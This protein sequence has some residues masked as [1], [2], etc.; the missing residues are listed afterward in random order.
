VRQAISG[1][2]EELAALERLLDETASG[3]AALILEGEPGIGKT[4]LFDAGRELARARG[5]VVLTAQPAP[6]EIRLAHA[7]LAD[8]LGPVALQALEALPGAQ[9]DA[10][11][12]AL[13]RNDATAPHAPDRRAVAAALLTVVEHLAAT[14]PVLIAIDD[15][16]WL[17][18]SSAAAVT[19]ALRRVTGSAG[20]LAARHPDPEAP[21]LQLAHGRDAPRLTIGP[22][23]RAPLQ[24]LVRA[25]LGR[26]LPP[27]V[28]ER[29]ERM[30]GG[31]P[32]F[33]IEVAR[34]IA[35]APA[36]LDVALPATLKDLVAHRLADLP[37][38]TRQALAVA[39]ALDRPAG[40]ALIQQALPDVDAVPALT[41][42]ERRDIIIFA[43]GAVQF[44]HPLLAA[45]VGDGLQP[46]QRRAIHG[47]LAGLVGDPE[48]RA[49]HLARATV[50][51]DLQTV[52]AL[53]DAA[54][55]A[56]ERGAPAAAAELLEHARALGADTPERRALTAIHHFDAGDADRARTLLES[57][58]AELD[59]PAAARGLLGTI[60]YRDGSYAEAA[61]ILT[62]ALQEAPPGTALAVTTALELSF[63]LA[64]QGLFAAAAPHVDR[65]AEAAAHLGDDGLLAQALTVQATVALLLGRGLDDALLSRA[66][67]L[68]DHT[69]RAFVPHQP[70]MLAALMYTTVGRAGEAWDAVTAVRERCRERGEDSELF[71][72]AIHAVTLACWRGDLD[73]AAAL[74]GE[75][76][77]QA[78]QLDTRTARAI[79]DFT[80]ALVAAWT[81]DVATARAAGEASLA[82][83]F[84]DG[85][86]V[87]AQMPL[88]ALAFLDL[89]LN[90]PEAAADRVGVFA[91]GVVAGGDA[92]EPGAVPFV[93]DAAEALAAAGRTEEAAPIV[94]WLRARGDALD[95]PFAQATGARAAALLLAARGD[96]AAAEDACDDALRHHDRLEALPLERARTLLALGRIRRRRRQRRAAREALEQALALFED[97]HAPLWATQARE[98]LARVQPRRTTPD[99]LTDAERR[100]A[101]L[102][103]GG[104]T[105]REVAAALFVSP[106]TVEAT[107]AR[108][109]RKL[110]IGSRAE[111]GRHMAQLP[112]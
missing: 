17:D 33:A 92:V 95:R 94:A 58:V 45:A 82:T 1:R 61:T 13:L 30:A 74:A 103:A 29:V 4:T 93:A 34:T 28:A 109:Y 16:Q 32:L 42:A 108:V 67:A 14:A 37:P 47:R 59:E 19:F 65:A 24:R 21:P 89:S 53:D 66:L 18:P 71:Y 23:A 84:Q 72:T 105:N 11:D 110:E 111:L 90:D 57:A 86:L 101:H 76:A 22:L 88:A 87:G 41:H 9:R 107:L 38:D 99:G 3:P 80:R 97:L 60:R 50:H 6:A 15:L 79:A 102:T 8:L 100:I 10:L 51:A 31:N 20:L 104:L 40:V 12:A 49:R 5:F 48:Q 68:E 44:T 75:A 54:V 73:Q 46:A 106:R 62:Q 2:T 96:L 39:A 64:N 7:G 83:F 35:Q 27:A 56:A 52:A 63:V 91:A 69:R 43:A 77:E 112:E 78:E 85:S 26:T 36:P 70:S 81:G 25:R 98:E 55:R